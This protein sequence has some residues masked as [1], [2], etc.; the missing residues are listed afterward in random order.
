MKFLLLFTAFALV[1]EVPLKPKEEFEVKLDYQLKQRPSDDP[2]TVRLSESPKTYNRTAS[3]VLPYLVLNI[4]LLSLREEKMRVSIATNLNARP[5]LK[6]VTTESMLELD[7]G[8]TDDI[9]DRVEAH[10]YTLTFVDADRNPV[11][12]ILI[13]V[14]DDGS[15]F[16]NGEKRGKF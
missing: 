8:F 14:A 3:G 15:F 12:R 13:S 2:N 11:D 4:K 6:K 1:Q 7:M 9:I 16:V 10:E 5:T